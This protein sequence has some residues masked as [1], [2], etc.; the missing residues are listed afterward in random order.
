MTSPTDSFWQDGDSATTK[1]GVTDDVLDLLFPF[2]CRDLPLD[3]MYDLYD[4]VRSVI[5]WIT[6]DPQ[7]AIHSIHGAESGAGWIR[8][9][10]VDDIIYL[11]K[12][13]RFILRV[14]KTKIDQCRAL[15]DKTLLV[16]GRKL[17]LGRFKTR[18]L[19][20]ETILFARYIA[21][22]QP[23]EEH[24]L[25]PAIADMLALQNISPKKI[26]SGRGHTIRFENRTLYCHSLMLDGLDFSVAQRLQQSGLGQYQKVGCGIFLP[27]KRISSLN[28]SAK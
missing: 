14:P 21:F 5:P 3:H 24:V 25:V 19:S 7:M 4:A 9:Q 2:Q 6:D 20:K 13:T 22:D 26:M 8:P 15:E 11:S 18:L 23:L 1:P 16:G 12:R 28:D 27:H 10:G 17:H